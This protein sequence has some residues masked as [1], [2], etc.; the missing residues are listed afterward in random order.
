ML[1][2]LYVKQESTQLALSIQKCMTAQCLLQKVVFSFLKQQQQYMCREKLGLLS[3]QK[4]CPELNF[5]VEPR[6]NGRNYT[7]NPSFFPATDS[8]SNI[9]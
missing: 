5:P 6:T 9:L 3:I 1:V 4:S 2:V 7:E 8:F